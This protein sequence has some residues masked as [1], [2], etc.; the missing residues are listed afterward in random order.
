MAL[1][2]CGL[3]FKEA[4]GDV[5]ERRKLREKLG[6]KNFKWYLDHVYPDIHIPEDKPGMFG[7]VRS[8]PS[9]LAMNFLI[10]YLHFGN[11]NSSLDS[12][13]CV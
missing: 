9:V 12:L 1:M 7:M 13:T 3:C 5:T 2:L 8:S 11:V 4:F 6:C 10:P